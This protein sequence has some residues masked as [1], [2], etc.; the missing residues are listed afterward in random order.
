MED[1]T[2]GKIA[3]ELKGLLGEPPLV[4]GEDEKAY[5]KLLDAVLKERNPQSVMDRIDVYDFVNKL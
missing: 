2:D 1:D 3:D 5:K 4:A